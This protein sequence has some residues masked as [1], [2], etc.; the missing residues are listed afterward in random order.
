[1][2]PERREIQDEGDRR[3][4][5]DWASVPVF[6]HCPIHPGNSYREC[7]REGH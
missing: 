5:R 1:M 6:M 7:K 4:E 2:T 3:I